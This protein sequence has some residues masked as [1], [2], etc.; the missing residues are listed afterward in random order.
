MLIL[1]CFHCKC[2]LS[3]EKVGVT[4][5]ECAG[6]ALAEQ[7]MCFTCFT[8]AVLAHDPGIARCGIEQHVVFLLAV[9]KGHGDHVAEI[10]AILVNGHALFLARVLRVDYVV[11]VTLSGV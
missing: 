3:T 5:L 11:H 10:L 8:F 6:I 9:A 2:L 4:Y 7:S 1:G